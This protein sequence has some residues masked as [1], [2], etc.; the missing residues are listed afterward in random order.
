[1]KEYQRRY[2]ERWRKGKIV[3]GI[4]GGWAIFCP[5]CCS[6]IADAPLEKIFERFAAFKK[7][8][9]VTIDKESSYSP[10]MREIIKGYESFGTY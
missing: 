6:S 10:K 7:Q 8:I 4:T 3:Y 2:N 9:F 5:S 1:L